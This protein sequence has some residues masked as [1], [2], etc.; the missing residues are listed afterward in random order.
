LTAATLGAAFGRSGVARRTVLVLPDVETVV[1]FV[2][3]GLGAA[4]VPSS[5]AA[6]APRNVEA[7]ELADRAARY[8][9]CYPAAS[10]VLAPSARPFWSSSSNRRVPNKRGDQ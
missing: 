7:L 6:I 3:L 10:G 5:V 9:L 8:P 1:R 4:V 2:A